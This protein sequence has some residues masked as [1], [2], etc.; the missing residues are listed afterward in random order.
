MPNINGKKYPYTPEGMRAAKK[1]AAAKKAQSRTGTQRPG[2]PGPA[3]GNGVTYGKR[4]TPGSKR[5]SMANRMQRKP[6]RMY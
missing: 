6:G 3:M 1:A 4:G 2:R 5:P